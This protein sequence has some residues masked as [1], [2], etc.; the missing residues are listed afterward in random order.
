MRYLAWLLALLVVPGCAI[1]QVA[2]QPTGIQTKVLI[3]SDYPVDSLPVF[4]T[5]EKWKITEDIKIVAITMRLC[6]M[7]LGE[8]NWQQGC[9]HGIAQVS[10]DELHTNDV[11]LEG[12]VYYRASGD[13]K[14]YGDYSAHTSITYPEGSW[15]EMRK[16]ESLYIHMMHEV[17]ASNPQ[18]TIYE[19]S[20][21]I[22][23]LVSE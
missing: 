12:Q 16:G 15:V 2:S 11:L 14:I 22:S 7:P 19:A 4:D 9:T 17:Y 21:V 10:R 8:D 3:I 23:Y 13:N 5:G 6:I 20:A 1:G 18:N